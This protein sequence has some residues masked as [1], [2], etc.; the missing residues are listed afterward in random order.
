MPPFPL[1]YRTFGK[2]LPPRPIRLEIPGWAGDT[3]KMEDGSVP[4]PWHC[5][6]FVEVSTY[7]LELIY[8][9]DAECHVANRSR[10]RRSL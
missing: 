1:K 4:Q 2:G 6:P 3:S 9:Y 5:N 8:P 10:K 7:G